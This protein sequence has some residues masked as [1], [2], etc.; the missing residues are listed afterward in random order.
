MLCAAAMTIMM[1][2]VIWRLCTHRATLRRD[3]NWKLL[4][5]LLPLSVY[6]ILS[7]IFIITPFVNRLYGMRNDISSD[8]R[9]ALSISHAI[10]AACWNLAT[11]LVFIVHVVATGVC[12]KR[13]RSQRAPFKHVQSEENGSDYHLSTA[14][15]EPASRRPNPT[16]NYGTWFSLP[17]PSV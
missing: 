12:S 3:K 5:Q 10:S 14:N 11:G 9:E 1:F 2:V 15:C 8:E 6:P 16:S 17:S 7:L 13:L 4:K